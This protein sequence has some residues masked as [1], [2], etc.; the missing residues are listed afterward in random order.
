MS[1]TKIPN[2]SK[3]HMAYSAILYHSKWRSS[4]T[5]YVNNPVCE[6]TTYIFRMNTFI[7][8]FKDKTFTTNK[9]LIFTI[10]T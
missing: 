2:A 4:T 10:Q 7:V 8:C 9:S 1:K 3:N 5:L 6:I